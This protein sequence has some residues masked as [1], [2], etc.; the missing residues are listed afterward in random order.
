MNPTISSLQVLFD[1]IPRRH[2][3]DNV[4]EIN[5]IISD[6][7]S[8]L[9]G[10]EAINSYYEKIA[11]SFFED[12]DNVR[13]AIKKSTENKNSKKAKDDYFAQG[14]GDLK[15]SMEALIIA[16]GNGTQTA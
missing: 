9:I 12:L 14:S 5:S 11:A 10:I 3:P 16:Y 8:L 6:Y 15:A 7:E 4:K 2:S 1:R 13:A